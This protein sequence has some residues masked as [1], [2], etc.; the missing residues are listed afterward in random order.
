MEKTPH[1]ATLAQGERKTYS[2]LDSRIGV[3]GRIST[4]P[5]WGIA[6]N[7]EHGG[8]CREWTPRR[9]LIDRLPGLGRRIC[10]GMRIALSGVAAVCW[11]DATRCNLVLDEMLIHEEAKANR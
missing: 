4:R 11:G 9:E 5:S 1:R 7:L 8:S 6:M 10:S 3:V 2:L